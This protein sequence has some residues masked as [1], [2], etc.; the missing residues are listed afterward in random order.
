MT[1]VH[2]LCVLLLL[3]LISGICVGFDVCHIL[4]QVEHDFDKN[5]KGNHIY[6]YL[7]SYLSAGLQ[8]SKHIYFIAV[9]EMLIKVNALRLI[10]ERVPLFK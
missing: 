5:K 2:A 7:S 3:D 10:F 9:I 1:R 4:I 6:L 8:T